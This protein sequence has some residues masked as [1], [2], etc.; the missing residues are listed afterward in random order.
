MSRRAPHNE[1]LRSQS[2]G[3]SFLIGQAHF[4][5]LTLPDEK[6]DQSQ[7]VATDTLRA[8]IRLTDAWGLVELQSLPY[9]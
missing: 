7:G 2:C 6:S 4:L 3:R 5:S 1:Y 9:S 8:K